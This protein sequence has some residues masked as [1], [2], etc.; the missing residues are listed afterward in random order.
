MEH[1]APDGFRHL[2][3]S[4]GRHRGWQRVFVQHDDDA[5]RA[6]SSRFGR[7]GETYGKDGE[8]RAQDGT[9]KGW[10]IPHRLS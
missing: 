4:D 6:P 5:L 1:L 9:A 2:L 3:G 7:R 10:P 8:Y